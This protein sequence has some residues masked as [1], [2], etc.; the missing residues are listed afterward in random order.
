MGVTTN[1]GLRYPSSAS[2]VTPYQHIQDLAS[3]ADAAI[4]LGYN[5]VSNPA[6]SSGSDTTASSA[7]VNMAGTGSVTSFP[8]TKKLAATKLVIRQHVGWQNTVG[9][10]QMSFGVSVNGVDYECTRH[11]ANATNTPLI[12]SGLIVISGLAAGTYT[13]QGR[14]KRRGGSG[15][16]TRS[17]DEILAMEAEER[18]AF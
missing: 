1:L 5:A 8:I 10:S 14:W 15:T 4:A 2:A 12:S 17:N 3:D 11:S 18:W 6:V 13:V 9:L 16:P 7:Y